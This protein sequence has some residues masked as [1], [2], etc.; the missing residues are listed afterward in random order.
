MNGENFANGAIGER[1]KQLRGRRSREIFARQMG[2]HKNTLANYER[3]KRNPDSA[4]LVTL[5]RKENVDPSWL[6]GT[7]KR[8]EKP[9]VR[10]LLERVANILAILAP[11]N[12]DGK[13]G[14]LLV[15]VYERAVEIEAE[16]SDIENIAKGMLELLNQTSRPTRATRRLAKARENKECQTG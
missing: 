14:I 15:N 6:L 5:C 12:V 2:I 10:S 7:P 4:F 8:P 1:I 9:Y 13:T 3:G 16:D 11:R